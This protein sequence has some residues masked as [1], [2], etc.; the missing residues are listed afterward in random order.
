MYSVEVHIV[1]NIGCKIT[2]DVV[3]ISQISLFIIILV[4]STHVALK[5][6]ETRV[7]QSKS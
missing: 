7:D 6:I 2:S 5:S 1:K 4:S 3:Y